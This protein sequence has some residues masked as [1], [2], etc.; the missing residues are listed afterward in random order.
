MKYSLYL[1][2]DLPVSLPFHFQPFIE[3]NLVQTFGLISHVRMFLSLARMLRLHPESRKRNEFLMFQT[4]IQDE[5]E[6]LGQIMH[7]SNIHFINFVSAFL[8]RYQLRLHW[9]LWHWWLFN[10]GLLDWSSNF[11]FWQTDIHFLHHSSFWQQIQNSY[12]S[13]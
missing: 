7:L 11:C 2:E 5:K 12:L 4:Q 13:H 1:W 10:A 3:V 6:K 8:I 9:S